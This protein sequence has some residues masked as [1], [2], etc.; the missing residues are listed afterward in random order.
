M[1]IAEILEQLITLG[2]VVTVL[3][4]VIYYLMKKLKQVEESLTI[5]NKNT[6]D[7]EKENILLLDSLSH[8]LDKLTEKDETNTDKLLTELRNL[9]DL[10]LAKLEGK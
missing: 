8:A 6:R 3:V 1:E 5:L 9:R 2:P 10:I 7:S 4:A